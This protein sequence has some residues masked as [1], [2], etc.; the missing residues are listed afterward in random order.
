MDQNLTTSASYPYVIILASGRSLR[1]NN[2]GQQAA[3]SFAVQVDSLSPVR[4]CM[5][6]RLGLWLVLKSRARPVHSYS[7]TALFN[8]G[9]ITRKP[10][11]DGA[12]GRVVSGGAS[13]MLGVVTSSFWARHLWKIAFMTGSRQWNCSG[14]GEAASLDVRQRPRD[15]PLPSCKASNH[16][17]GLHRKRLE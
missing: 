15:Q 13:S 10:K 14:D 8:L 11:F 9:F 7:I 6:M 1:R 17:A 3:A 12:T 4:P 16:M 2:S 5:N